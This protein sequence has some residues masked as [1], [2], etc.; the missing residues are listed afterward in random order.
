MDRVPKRHHQRRVKPRATGQGAP[1][2]IQRGADAQIRALG[3]R[4]CDCIALPGL[5]QET[6]RTGPGGDLLQRRQACR[7]GACGIARGERPGNGK[8]VAIGQIAIGIMAKDQRL[9]TGRREQRCQLAVK[10][11]NPVL[12]GP[13]ICPVGFGVFRILHREPVGDGL[14][15]DPGIDRI[16][17]GMGIDAVMV[18]AVVLDVMRTFRRKMAP[19]RLGKVQQPEDGV[20]TA[21]RGQAVKPGSHLGADPDQKLRVLERGSLRRAKLIVVG[22]C[23]RIHQND[24]FAQ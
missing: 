23:A 19:V 2:G 5:G 4:P 22:I 11:C 14:H 24:G 16:E 9:A 18:M 15:P 17:P 20:G 21:G 13:G 3:Q 8:P 7:T 12:C 10:R 6:G 1:F